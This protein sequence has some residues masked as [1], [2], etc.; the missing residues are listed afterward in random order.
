M[1]VFD[2]ESDIGGRVSGLKQG[3]AFY[4]WSVRHGWWCHLCTWQ[5]LAVSLPVELITLCPRLREAGPVTAQLVCASEW[6]AL[7]FP[8]RSICTLSA[9]R[10]ENGEIEGGKKTP[11]V[12][13]F[14]KKFS[15]SRKLITARH[16]LQHSEARRSDCTI[17][18]CGSGSWSV[19][20]PSLL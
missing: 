18:M 17:Q 4:L 20:T 5:T 8:F 12:K 10:M 3:G 6:P 11:V 7:Q 9:V 1:L 15:C 2:N 14:L 19:S 13:C 16:P